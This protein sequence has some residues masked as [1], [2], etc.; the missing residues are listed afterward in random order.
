MSNASAI[1]VG[2]VVGDV[3]IE[4][5]GFVELILFSVVRTPVADGDAAD[6]DDDDN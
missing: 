6:G 1:G 3:G 5:H 2:R 4:L